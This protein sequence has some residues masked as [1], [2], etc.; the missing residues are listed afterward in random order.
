MFDR[1][2]GLLGAPASN[3][4][5]QPSEEL[6]TALLLLELGRADFDFGELEQARIRELLAARFA[7]TAEQVEAL[8]REART[9]VGQAVS[10]HSYVQTLNQ[11]LDGEGK[12][13]LMTMLWQVAWADGR[14][15]KHEEH[16]LRRLADLL[17]V[18]MADYIRIKLA[19]SGEAT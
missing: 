5:R 7:L 6:A 2:R 12:R 1:L 13:A 9:D 16:L 14:L 17:Y 8:L 18:P 10:L 11:R 4:S 15:D 3:D 19:V